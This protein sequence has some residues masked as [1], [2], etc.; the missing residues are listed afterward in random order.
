[1]IRIVLRETQI[2]YYRRK[3]KPKYS[4]LKPTLVFWMITGCAEKKLTFITIIVFE[5]NSL[6]THEKCYHK[7]FSKKLRETEFSTQLAILPSFHIV[8]HF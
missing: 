2:F 8:K 5:L 3:P 4:R 6:D 1:M 7:D